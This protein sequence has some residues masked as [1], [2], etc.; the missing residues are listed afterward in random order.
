MFPLGI[1]RA[2]IQLDSYQFATYVSQVGTVLGTA[3]LAPVTIPLE[4]PAQLAVLLEQSQTD[5]G[6]LL[7]GF[8]PVI[9][10]DWRSFESEWEMFKARIPEP[11]KLNND[12]REF[13]VGERMRDRGLHAD[14]PVV[15]IPGIVSTGLESWSTSDE[16]R[17]WFREKVWGGLRYA[18]WSLHLFCP[19]YTFRMISQVTFNRDKWIT[20]LM[21][22]PVTGLDPPGV[23]VR[24]AQGMSLLVKRPCPG[25]Y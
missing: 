19:S 1:F 23:K 24:A 6:A 11:W 9:D 25:L 13:R 16:Y 7:S 15:I 10:I 12:G 2:L 8:L 3:L 4:M 21:L 14:H 18:L 22:D 17:S 20:S 5:V